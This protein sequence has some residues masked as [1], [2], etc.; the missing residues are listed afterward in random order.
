MA[1]EFL[2]LSS[3]HSQPRATSS[4]PDVRLVAL[5][6]VVAPVVKGSREV[7]ERTGSIDVSKSSAIPQSFAFPGSR[8]SRLTRKTRRRVGVELMGAHE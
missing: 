2:T 8:G 5:V 1:D 6:C 7:P 4:K 3:S